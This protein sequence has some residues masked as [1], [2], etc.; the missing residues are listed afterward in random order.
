VDT[1]AGALAR[2]LY[3]NGQFQL[4][5][6]AC[7][8]DFVSRSGDTALV[9]NPFAQDF[10]ESNPAR[11]GSGPGIRDPPAVKD[12]LRIP[13]LSKCPVKRNEYSFQVRGKIDLVP[14]KI[15]FYNVITRVP[16]PCRYGAAGT[17]GYFTLRRRPPHKNCYFSKRCHILVPV[18]PPKS[19]HNPSPSAERLP[20][21]AS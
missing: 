14:G 4:A 5:R 3:Y 10:V 16:Q 17:Q 18:P 9:E 15:H 7:T 12:C 8:D 6:L 13:I 20:V 19:M 11:K 2:G 21:S 1:Y